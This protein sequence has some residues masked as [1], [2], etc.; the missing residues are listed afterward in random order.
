[1]PR[2]LV[3]AVTDNGVRNYLRA[4]WRFLGFAQREKETGENIADL[5]RAATWAMEHMAYEEQRSSQAGK[6]L[7]AGLLHLYPELKDE[8]PISARALESWEKL[9]GDPE[10][11]PLCRSLLAIAIAKLSEK[12]DDMAW[13]VWSQSREL[14]REQDVENLRASDIL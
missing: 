12:S 1:M 14:L 4:I 9:E 6:D 10:R 7:R 5:D 8:L 2:L 13:C 11:E 3:H